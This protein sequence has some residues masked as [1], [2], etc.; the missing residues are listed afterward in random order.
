MTADRGFCFLLRYLV[1]CPVLSLPLLAQGPY[2]EFH[3]IP[4]SGIGGANAFSAA[5]QNVNLGMYGGANFFLPSSFSPLV[6][7]PVPG[8]TA[9]NGHRGNRHH[10]HPDDTGSVI[11]EP[12]YI[13]YAVPYIAD[14]GE[15]LVEDQNDAGPGPEEMAVPARSPAGSPGARSHGRTLASKNGLPGPAEARGPIID[16]GLPLYGQPE[17]SPAGAAVAPAAVPQEP[18]VAQPTTVLVFKDGRR[19]E[20]GNYAIVGGTLFDFSGD[21]ARKIQIADLDL[22]ATQ[23]AND[24]AGVEFKLPPGAGP[25]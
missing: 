12:V 21:R 23:K 5:R 10:H 17:D 25:N 9:G 2:L 4:P 6:P 20:V 1:F 3:G 8:T 19:S 11:A 7:Y 24:A 13:P 15:D 22:A 14:P 16:N 18:V